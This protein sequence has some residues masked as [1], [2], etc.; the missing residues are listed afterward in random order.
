MTLVTCLAKFHFGGWWIVDDYSIFLSNLGHRKIKERAFQPRQAIHNIYIYTHTYLH[1]YMHAYIHTYIDAY[2]HTYMH[3]CMHTYIHAYIYIYTRGH[4]LP[5]LFLFATARFLVLQV[6]WTRTGEQHSAGLAVTLVYSLDP[7]H[8]HPLATSSGRATGPRNVRRVASCTTPADMG[9]QK[10]GIA[11][12]S[13]IF[14]I[15]V[16]DD[17]F[18]QWGGYPQIIP[19]FWGEFPWSI[20]RA[21]FM[22]SS[23]TWFVNGWKVTAKSII[24]KIHG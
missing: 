12:N 3:A 15:F 11:L 9:G 17:G 8:H 22:S 7:Q 20:Q 21:R 6:R 2:I 23:Q 4:D 10:W 1:T 19:I 13:L 16:G 24:S 5:A 18:H 14:D